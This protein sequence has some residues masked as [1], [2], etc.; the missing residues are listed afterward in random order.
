MN[1]LDVQERLDLSLVLL[2]TEVERSNLRKQIRENVEKKISETQ[3]KY[4]LQ[5]QLK[6]IKNELGLQKDDKETLLTKFNA[7]LNEEGIVV[8]KEAQQV[9][10]EEM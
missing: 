7:R 3:R 4:M 5:E 10:D 6:E 2:K 8:P 9:I 1:T